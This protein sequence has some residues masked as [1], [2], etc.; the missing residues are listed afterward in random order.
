MERVT[1]VRS[2]LRCGRMS[3]ARKKS[4]KSEVGLFSSLGSACFCIGRLALGLSKPEVGLFSSLGN[5]CF[6]IGRLA[7]G[8]SKPEVGIFSPWGN[9]CFCIWRLALGLLAVLHRHRV[10]N[11]AEDF[12]A[13]WQPAY[14]AVVVVFVLH[15]TTPCFSV[16]WTLSGGAIGCMLSSLV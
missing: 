2:Y 5:A 13:V 6:C 7:L 12:L 9:A 11:T 4:G 16:L 10:G 1:R 8:L 3:L 14:S 15:R